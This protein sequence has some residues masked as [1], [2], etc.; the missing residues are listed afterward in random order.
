VTTLCAIAGAVMILNAAVLI[1]AGL[2]AR[3]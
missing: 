1:V 3:R 2:A